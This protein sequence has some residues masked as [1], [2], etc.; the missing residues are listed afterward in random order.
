MTARY[1]AQLDGKVAKPAVTVRQAV[2]VQMLGRRFKFRQ[3]L[4]QY[5][6]ELPQGGR[7]KTPVDTP[8]GSIH[9]LQRPEDRLDGTAHPLRRAPADGEPILD[10]GDG[11]TAS[12]TLEV[13]G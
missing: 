12:H 2:T 4:G 3:L 1:G 13:N 5:V 7:L 9:G 8:V 11:H 10:V 6:D